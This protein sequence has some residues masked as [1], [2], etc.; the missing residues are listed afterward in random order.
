MAEQLGAILLRNIR[1]KVFPGFLAKR[2]EEAETWRSD[3][4]PGFCEISRSSA[5]I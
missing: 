5:L 2:A 1:I 3:S 4:E